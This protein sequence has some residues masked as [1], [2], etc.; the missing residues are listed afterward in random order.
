MTWRINRAL[1]MGL[2]SS[3]TATMPAAFIADISASASPLLPT[4]AAPIGQTRTELA[5]A[6][7]STIP[8]VTDALSFTGCVFGMQQT[9]V[10]PP[11]AAARVPVSLSS[12]IRWPGSRRWQRRSMKPGATTMPLASNISAPGAERFAPIFE[13]RSPSRSTSSAASVLLAGSRTRPFLIRSIRSVLCGMR[14]VRGR[15]C[16]KMVEQCHAHG[17]TIGDLFEH[18]RLRT[19]GHGGIDFEASNHRARMQDEGFG[20]REAQTLRGELVA[21]DVF[22]GG[23]GRLVNALGLNAQD[24]DDIGSIERL[25]DARCAANPWRKAFELARHP[26][27]R[28]T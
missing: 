9:A 6:A 3:L 13:I 25:F 10:N 20:T 19:V 1:A 21:G 18:A 28:A 24:H 22:L 16:E 11:R 7:R 4:D 15:A 2:P 27:R 5:A 23:K 14:R 26:H 12:S 8:R 17:E